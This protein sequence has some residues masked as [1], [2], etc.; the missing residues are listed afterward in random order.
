[1][2]MAGAM[3]VDLAP[4]PGPLNCMRCL[5]TLTYMPELVAAPQ[6]PDATAGAEPALVPSICV[7]LA[8]EAR[9]LVSLP[10]PG[11]WR[12]DDISNSL[13]PTYAAEAE[14]R[15]FTVEAAYS[16]WRSTYTLGAAAL[17]TTPRTLDSLPLDFASLALLGGLDDFHY[18]RDFVNASITY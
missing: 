14:S 16:L 13:L 12:F 10:T 17:L 5:L 1:M 9:R 8:D 7:C 15:P 3:K 2:L 4:G 6:Q 11:P 18:E